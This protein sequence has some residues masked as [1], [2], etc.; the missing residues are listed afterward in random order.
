MKLWLSRFNLF[1]NRIPK[2]M[3]HWLRSVLGRLTSLSIGMRIRKKYQI[4]LFTPQVKHRSH[5][6]I[7]NRRS[8]C[9]FKKIYAP[10][11]IVR[12]KFLFYKLASRFNTLYELH[13]KSS[14]KAYYER[15]IK[16][17]LFN[18]NEKSERKQVGIFNNNEISI[19]SNGVIT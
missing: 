15:K 2:L 3:Q 9:R 6:F 10:C 19:P 14:S 13:I 1:P 17:I 8:W 4:C 16:I 11:F 5:N 12:L 18:K 7:W